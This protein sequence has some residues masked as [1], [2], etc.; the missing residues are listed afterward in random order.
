MRI[1]ILIVAWGIIASQIFYG[2][3]CNDKDVSKSEVRVEYYY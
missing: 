2:G 1:V 3:G